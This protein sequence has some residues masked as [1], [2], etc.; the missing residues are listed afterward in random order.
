MPFEI[1]G[2][3]TADW[4]DYIILDDKRYRVVDRGE[5][6]YQ[7]VYDRQKTD[8]I[9]LTGLTILQD[10]TVS[11][12]EPHLWKLILRVFIGEAPA[13]EWGLWADLLVAYR[14]QVVEM[15][16]FDGISVFDVTIRS[17]LVP[18]PRVGANLSGLC[19]GIFFVETTIVEVYQ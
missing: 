13:A 18:V 16:F 5:G 14:E 15:T 9:G 6:S 10:F 4:V 8:E 12:R 1:T 19:E 11:A 3:P 17:P 7:P 2:D